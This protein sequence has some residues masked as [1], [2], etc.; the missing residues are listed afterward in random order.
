MKKLPT[1]EFPTAWALETTSLCNA[2]CVMCVARDGV[3]RSPAVMPRE[4][5]KYIVNQ[6]RDQVVHVATLA[7]FGEPL[8]DPHIVER[9]DHLRKT[10]WSGMQLSIWTNGTLMTSKRAHALLE[11]G[12]SVINFSIDSIHEGTYELIRVGLAFEDAIDGITVFIR[13]NEDHGHPCQV[14]MHATATRLNIPE[15][16]FFVFYWLNIIGV[17]LADWIPAELSRT[18]DPDMAEDTGTSE[19]C[20]SPFNNFTVLSD[21]TVVLCCKD[22]DGFMPLGNA[23]EQ[24]IEEIWTSEQYKEIRELHN[25]GRKVEIPLCA[26]C[27]AYR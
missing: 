2:K 9:V 5:F 27:G 17:D 11:V 6:G 16:D 8:L 3:E 20:S 19:P 4:E 10:L 22:H 26:D 23:F 15:M 13:A 18:V 1:K 25:S 21:G 7:H 12:L 14:R 24:S